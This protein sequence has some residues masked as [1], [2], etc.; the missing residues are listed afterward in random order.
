M[1][2]HTIGRDYKTVAYMY[3]KIT[4]AQTIL[5]NT[6]TAAAEIDRVL[7]ACLQNK[8]P[9]YIAVPSDMVFLHIPTPT[10]PF[11]MS[12]KEPSHRG[13]LEEAVEDIYERLC[14]SSCPVFIPG[15]EIARRGLQSSFL[16]L[17]EVSR[18][19]FATMMLSKGVVDEHH[20]Q[21]LG[22]Y[23][24]SLCRKY[25]RD[26]VHHSDCLILWGE[27]LTDFNTGGFTAQ[28]NRSKTIEA[29]Y[30]NVRVG[31]RTYHRVYIHDL[32][33]LLKERVALRY[34]ALS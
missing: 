13:A 30:D 20:P 23:C 5:D 18:V 1:L 32:L 15:I 10:T 19:P 4:T 25:I 3:A 24:G 26:K 28:L 31:H 17:L 8:M 33:Q 21:F 9:A 27:K 34:A 29:N 22:V 14:H 2:H 12:E 11:K 6:E 7:T 16:D